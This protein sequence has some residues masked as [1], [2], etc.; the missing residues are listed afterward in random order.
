MSLLVE[1]TLRGSAAAILVLLLDAATRRFM[2]ARGRRWWWLILPFA[3]LLP[4]RLP[5][6]PRSVTEWPGV[7]LPAEETAALHDFLGGR[8]IPPASP[9]WPLAEVLLVLWLL[10]LACCLGLTIFQTLRTASRWNHEPHSLDLRLL[11]LLQ[12]ARAT[13]GVTAPIAL[14]ISPR[15]GTPALLGWLRPRILLPEPMAAQFTDAQLRLVFLHEL[16]HFRS[17]DIPVG[18]LYAL[19]RCL[20]WFNP[21]PWLAERQWRRFCEEAADE[22]VITWTSDRSAYGE[23]L[24][25]AAS[26]L[27]SGSSPRPYGSLAIG[28]NFTALKHRLTMITRTRRPH[29]LLTILCSAVL[30]GLGFLQA[31]DS[32]PKTA[33]VSAMEKWMHVID[34]G[35]Y[36]KSWKD[37]ASS[38]QKAVTEEQWIQALNA[39][40][41]PLG[42]VK[43]RELVSAL[44]QTE[45]P[46]GNGEMLKGDYVIAQFK[47]SYQNLFSALETVTFERDNGEWKASGYFVKPAM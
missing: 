46:T 15:I 34:E 21:L 32:D 3:F 41:A 20:H 25:D 47:S 9:G 19:A 38:F 22:R 14:V 45:I 35:K 31:E 36:A 42:K 6:L 11:T 18:W 30:L 5:V 26:R 28:E 40:R 13:A 10:G 1:L 8:L 29:A 2:Q 33:A 7:P 16:A 43:S 23:T 12:E 44:H 39:A 37:A 17:L 4:W 27:S 24:V